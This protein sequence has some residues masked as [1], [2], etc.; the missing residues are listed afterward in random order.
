MLIQ[1][2][3]PLSFWVGV[4]RS[5]GGNLEGNWFD[6]IV[7][8]CFIFVAI[9]LLSKRQISWGI[10]VQQN[11]GLL[12][13]YL[14][15]LV[16][17][18]WAPFPFVLFKRWFRD[19]GAIFIILLVLTEEHPMEAT[20]ALFARCAYVWFPVSEILGKY[21]PGIGREYSKGGAAMYSGVCGEKNALGAI[22]LIASLF[23]ITELFEAN[24]PLRNRP[25]RGGRF[26][27]YLNGHHF[28]ILVT[29]A[30]GMWVLYLSQSRTSQ[31]CLLIGVMIVFS[32]RVPIL[33]ASP[34]RVVIICLLALPIFYVSDALFGIS[35]QLLRLI[36]RNPTL[37]DRTEIWEAVKKNPVNP[38]IGVGYMMYWDY[39][40]G[41]E[42]RDKTAALTTAHNGYI[43]TYLDGGALALFFL[44]VMLLAVGHRAV[45]EFL[46]GSE[47]GRL[48]FAFFVI[49]L[50]NNVTE[51]TYGR[52]SPLWFTFLLFALEFR[53]CWPSP[54]SRETEDAHEVWTDEPAPLVA[55]RA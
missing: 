27:G 33:K 46:T 3:R 49:M 8:M 41:I 16:T 28:T 19:I 53:G 15:L 37:T 34:R 5:A 17:I 52:R 50:L 13:F 48:A 40:G 9:Y 51:S 35:G 36:G 7:A 4:G 22:V 11:K 6:R 23:L 30:M 26:T 45:R 38:I 42:L 18:L 25:L 21:F 32:H 2:S 24:R 54:V 20:K 39:F 10:L 55:G 31:I 43:D 44:A 12:L 47:Y 14:F 1:G 29:L